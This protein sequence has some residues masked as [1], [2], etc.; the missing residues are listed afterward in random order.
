MRIN[1]TVNMYTFVAMRCRVDVMSDRM[2]TVA[3]CFQGWK[4]SNDKRQNLGTVAIISYDVASES[5][6]KSYIKEDNPFVD[7]ICRLRIRYALTSIKTSRF[8]ITKY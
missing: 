5:V 1:L 4:Y 8:I 2:P 3:D 6:I 7:K